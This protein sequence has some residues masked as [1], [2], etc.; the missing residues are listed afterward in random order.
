MA[1]GE[2]AEEGEVRAGEGRRR[3]RRQQ[4]AL[5]RAAEA[6]AE[7]LQ[8]AAEAAAEA[9]AREEAEQPLSVTAWTQQRP[10]GSLLELGVYPSCHRADV[11]HVEQGRRE[12]EMREEK[13]R[14]RR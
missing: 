10:R 4:R 9:E 12:L 11:R 5:Q 6:E 14:E 8:R 13:N 3:E 7:A 2:G 1:V